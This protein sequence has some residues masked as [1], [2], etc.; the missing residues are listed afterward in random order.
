M[1]DVVVYADLAGEPTRLAVGTLRMHIIE[2]AGRLGLRVKDS[3]STARESF[4]GLPVFD[5]DPSRRVRAHV[6]PLPFYKRQA[7][8]A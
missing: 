3:S 2:R 7:T 5:Y 1:P 6:V 8:T 4:T